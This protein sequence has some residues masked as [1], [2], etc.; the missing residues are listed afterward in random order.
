MSSLTI[1]VMDESVA[2]NF[3]C[4][5][6]SN[7]HTFQLVNEDVVLVTDNFSSDRTNNQFYLHNILWR[8]HQFQQLILAVHKVGRRFNSMGDNWRDPW[9]SGI[10]QYCNTPVTIIVLIMCAKCRHNL[11]EGTYDLPADYE[12]PIVPPV[13]T[14]PARM[15]LEMNVAYE[16]VKSFDMNTNSAYAVV[17]S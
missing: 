9:C 3:T 11:D 1:D 17:A 4:S 6:P 5:G 15:P 12:K 14:I 10:D 8:V 7:F 2:D 13:G 16:Q